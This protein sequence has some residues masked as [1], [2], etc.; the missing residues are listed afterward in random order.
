MNG[1]KRITAGRKRQIEVEGYTP[2]HDAQHTRGELAQAAACYLMVDEEPLVRLRW[3][4]APVA[5]NRVGFP[6]PCEIDLVK[7]G[8][9]AAAELDRRAELEAK[10]RGAR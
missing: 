2:E 7:G 5:F 10:A 9:L 4:W 6:Y 3:P 8:A 1:A